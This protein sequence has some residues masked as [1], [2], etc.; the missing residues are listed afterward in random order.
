MSSSV[1]VKTS[2]SIGRSAL[3]V[4][5]SFMFRYSSSVLCA[6]RYVMLFSM[7]MPSADVLCEPMTMPLALLCLSPSNLAN[8]SPPLLL[9]SSMRRLLLM[10]VFHKAFWS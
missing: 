3:T 9:S 1:S 4:V 6:F 7:Q 2:S 8:I 5:S 10:F